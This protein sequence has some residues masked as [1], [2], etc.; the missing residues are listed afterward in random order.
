MARR[1]ASPKRLNAANLSGLGAER[2]GELLMQAADADAILKRRLRLVMAAEAG[3]DL[4]ALEI[5]KRL[6][7][8]A[9][10]RAR[11]SWRKRPD[12]LRD[13]EIL[14]AAIVDDLAEAAPAMGLERLIG[15]FDLFRG[16]ASRVKD[17]KG[18]LADAFETAA[19]DL[20]RI[21]EAAVR[22][23]DSTVGLM[24]DA[25]ARQP[26]EY[27]RWIGAG[28]DDLTA[29]LAKRLL[30]R[31]DTASSA[32]GMRTVVRRLADRAGDLDLWLSMTTPEERG[33]PDFAAMMAKRLLVA[34]R[35]PEACQ[36][37]EA[38]LKPSA[39][40]RR[41]T[42]GRSPQEGPPVL[43]P[44]WEA[45]SI[46]LLEA[47]GRKDEAQDL[48]WAMFERDLSAPV[49]RAYLARLPDFDDV[50]ALD[51]ALAHAAT[52]ADVETALAFLMDWPSHREAAALVERRIREVRA[53]LPLKA[54]WAAR[55][56]QK[57]PDAAERL[58]AA[59]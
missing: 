55:L 43:T 44:A 30:D 35:I 22:T 19:S 15:W 47:E 48:R 7:T 8:I 39:G 37:L 36:A 6:T 57:Y 23:D 1:P 49:L 20:W 40:N 25:V 59:G 4:L 13:L 45:T 51:R 5:D 29:D 38:A 33:S 34:D 11:V 54:D 16:L 28:G 18:E 24:A 53:P 52:Y 26:L 17:Q 46:D 10:S 27:A 32:R 14:R 2:L 41:W 21:A 31:L 12:L 58:L 42:F 9:A 50:E 3:P 56:V